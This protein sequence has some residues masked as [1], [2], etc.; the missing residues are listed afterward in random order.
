[1]RLKEELGE[2]AEGGG[3]SSGDAIGRESLHDASN[4]AM[5]LFLAG[6]V[7]GEV[8]QIGGEFVVDDGTQASQRSVRTAHSVAG[9]NGGVAADASIGIFESAK[10]VR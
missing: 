5:N 2:I 9:G 10:V 7:A 6:N 1:M 4:G 3:A 8:G